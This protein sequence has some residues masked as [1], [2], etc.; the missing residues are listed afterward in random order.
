MTNL[1]G[2]RKFI[3]HADTSSESRLYM[4]IHGNRTGLPS[5][6]SL[7]N[8]GVNPWK[9]MSHKVQGLTGPPAWERQN[10]LLF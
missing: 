7:V 10:E 3:N 6:R 4:K 5:K 1:W 8:N 9:N 2:S